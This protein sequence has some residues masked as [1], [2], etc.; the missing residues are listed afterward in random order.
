MPSIRFPE[1][2]VWIKRAAQGAQCGPVLLLPGTRGPGGIVRCLCVEVCAKSCCLL[3]NRSLGGITACWYVQPGVRM[4][5]T[6]FKAQ[7]T[8]FILIE[9]V[10]GSPQTVWSS[11]EQ[12]GFALESDHGKK[13]SLFWH[14]FRWPNVYIIFG[15]FV[16]IALLAWPKV[17]NYMRE[18]ILY[19]LLPDAFLGIPAKFQ[20]LN[21]YF[22]FPVN[23][24]VSHMH[25]CSLETLAEPLLFPSP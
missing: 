9:F 16:F 17:V 5:F 19:L 2:S 20:L 24:G 11:K 18:Q 14:I 7:S 4:L 23:S 25:L 8:C 6:F 15:F 10:L 3:L 1:H 13:L 21:T 12:T 22:A